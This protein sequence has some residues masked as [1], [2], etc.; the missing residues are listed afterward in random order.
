MLI[1]AILGGLVFFALWNEDCL[2]GE[3]FFIQSVLTICL[4]HVLTSSS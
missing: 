2:K 3:I 1:Q 4:L